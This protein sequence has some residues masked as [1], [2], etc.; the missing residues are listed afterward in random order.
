MGHLLYK[1]GQVTEHALQKLKNEA[2][3]AGKTSF[4]FAWI[5]DDEEEE[6]E[7]G[8]TKDIGIRYFETPAKEFAIL[9]APGHRDYIPNMI[10][11]AVQAD[12]AILVVDAVSGAFEAGFGDRGQTKEHLLLA[13]ALGVTQLCVVVNKMDAYNWSEERFGDIKDRVTMFLD[14]AG[15]GTPGSVCFFI[16]IVCFEVFN[17]FL[18][19][20]LFRLLFLF[21]AQD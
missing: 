4:H 12:G 20:F 2:E 15:F 13:R 9:D 3:K 6:R 11:G 5:M 14:Q 10:T 21:H 16:L 19:K 17:K 7:H 1:T 18:L 8:V